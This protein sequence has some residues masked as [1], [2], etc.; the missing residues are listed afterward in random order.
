MDSTRVSRDTVD[1]SN[2]FAFDAGIGEICHIA[3]NIFVDIRYQ[4]TY[5]GDLNL[6]NLATYYTNDNM[7]LY[8]KNV[9]TN[10]FTLGI[11]VCF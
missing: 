11:G 3:E 9:Y 6:T 2:N 4:F 7:K 8:I 5:L 10:V 1:S